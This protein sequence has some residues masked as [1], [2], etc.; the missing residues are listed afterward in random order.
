MLS[1]TLHSLVAVFFTVNVENIQRRE[2]K[3]DDRSIF[4][5]LY[6]RKLRR[7]EPQHITLNSG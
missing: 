4:F 7:K 5:Y 2:D 1:P 3:L 6:R